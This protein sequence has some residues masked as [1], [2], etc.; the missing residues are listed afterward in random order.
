MRLSIVGLKHINLDTKNNMKLIYTLI[1]LGIEVLIVYTAF[2]LDITLFKVL[3][4]MLVSLIVVGMTVKKN[5]VKLSKFNFSSHIPQLMIW[6]INY[7]ILYTHNIQAFGF[8]Y[9]LTTTLLM[10]V[11]LHNKIENKDQ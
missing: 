9:L 2:V 7:W 1:V 8:T 11:I 6:G 3:A 10:A 4:W 5:M